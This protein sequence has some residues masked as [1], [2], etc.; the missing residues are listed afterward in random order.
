MSKETIMIVDDDEDLSTYL[1]QEL[2][3]EGY[4]VMVSKDGQE[5]LMKIRQIEPDL[6]ILD[7]EMPKMAGIDV[8]KRL[9]TN[10][11]IP[12]LML[13]AK[14]EV[15]DRVQGID[16]GAN[17]YLVKPFE[18]DELLARIRGILRTRKPTAKTFKFDQSGINQLEWLP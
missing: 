10:S 7:W 18:L 15:K 13:T 5:G 1:K 9:R 2:E 11:E 3:I 6:V 12:V 17:D 8:L 4:N 14:A 16:L